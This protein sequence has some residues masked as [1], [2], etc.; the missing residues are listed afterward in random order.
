MISR[1]IQPVDTY[2]KQ[3][4]IPCHSIARRLFRV[5]QGQATRIGNRPPSVG[6]PTLLSFGMYRQLSKMRRYC[7]SIG[8][9]SLAYSAGGQVSTFAAHS[10]ARQ[11]TC[12]IRNLFATSPRRN[13][14]E[15]AR[16]A[17]TPSRCG[18]QRPSHS[19]LCRQDY[20]VWRQQKGAVASCETTISR[21]WPISV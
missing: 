16:V 20:E 15:N 17:S 9:T 7:R 13:G 14:L 11:P 6:T 1:C 10:M 2:L 18:Y 3:I 5:A 4:L 8:A 12:P 19:N 21:P